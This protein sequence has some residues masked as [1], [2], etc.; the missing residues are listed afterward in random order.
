VADSTTLRSRGGKFNLEPNGELLEPGTHR[1]LCAGADDR[2]VHEL[3]AAR[4]ESVDRRADDPQGRDRGGDGDAQI[5]D[6]D[7]PSGDHALDCP[8]AA[9]QAPAR[10]ARVTPACRPRARSR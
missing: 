9:A 7:A 6:D 5:I 4:D 3:G 8:V 1:A 10:L 2:Y